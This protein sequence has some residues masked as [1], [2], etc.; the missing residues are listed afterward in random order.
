MIPT[1]YF[2]NVQQLNSI[3]NQTLSIELKVAS[4]LQTFS[5]VSL[6][7]NLLLATSFPTV[8]WTAVTRLVTFW[9]G[10][11]LQMVI[12]ILWSIVGGT[13]ESK[14]QQFVFGW[15]SIGFYQF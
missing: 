1:I 10:I 6:L 4:I 7:F 14:L 11:I 9:I 2:P 5:S 15:L 13:E 3:P 12:L 8:Q